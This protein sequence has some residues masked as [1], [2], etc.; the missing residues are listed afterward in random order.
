[1]RK[2]LVTRV[3]DCK[4][5]ETDA[6]RKPVRLANVDVPCQGKGGGRSAIRC[7]EKLIL[8]KVVSIKD[9][10]KYSR[11]EVTSN[12]N[13]GSVFVNKKMREKLG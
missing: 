12:V 1:M 9:F 10:S 4:T 8:N 13:I 7:L 2:E 11:G 3:I 6:R 5:F